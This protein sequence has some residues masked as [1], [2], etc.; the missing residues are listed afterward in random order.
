[1]GSWKVQVPQVVDGD[2]ADT[3]ADRGQDVSRNEEHVWGLADHFPREA[4][5]RPQAREGNMAHVG[6]GKRTLRRWIAEVEPESAAGGL[7]ALA[8]GL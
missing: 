5:V 2:E 6:F 1:M 3:W 7:G 8:L 4:Q